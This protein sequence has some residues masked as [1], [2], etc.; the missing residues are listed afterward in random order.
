MPASNDDGPRAN[1]LRDVADL[2]VGDLPM[3]RLEL[4]DE[5]VE[6]AQACLVGDM[7][8]QRVIEPRAEALGLTAL[9]SA[10]SSL[11]ERSVHGR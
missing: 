4:L 5:R 1:A 7:T 9:D 6:C 11:D 2:L 8:L 3:L 10:L